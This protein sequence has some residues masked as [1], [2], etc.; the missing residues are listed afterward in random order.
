MKYL[1]VFATSANACIDQFL[2]LSA[3]FATHKILKFARESHGFGFIGM[4][5]IYMNKFARLIPSYY[6]VFATGWSLVF[7]I[8]DGP[9]WSNYDSLFH[10]CNLYWW[11]NL[12]FINN[13]V[14]ATHKDSQ[15][16]MLWGSYVAVEI[17]LFILLPIILLLYR[18]RPWIA[19]SIFT[20]L[21]VGGTL[22][23]AYVIYIY[24]I[25]P[26]YLFPIDYQVGTVYGIKPYTRINS[27]AAGALMGLYYQKILWYRNEA[28]RKDKKSE[29]FLNWIHESRAA[30]FVLH[31]GSLLCFIFYILMYLDANYFTD[32]LANP[33]LINS[34]PHA[35]LIN[36]I[37]MAIGKNFYLIGTT[38]FL[39]FL[40]SGHNFYY[41][42]FFGNYA[43]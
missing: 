12:G 26:G 13:F 4:A 40:F 31:I 18:I 23:C 7:W 3:F 25:L 15:G 28:R 43:F 2:Y 11:A 24:A 30:P 33:E 6:F 16:C 37:L 35:Y 39:L 19:Y 17:Q 20:A 42:K 10:E 34:M 36:G 21:F 38:L 5:K 14:P 27:Y 9:L 1:W 32:N 29:R 22:A 8:G 41:V